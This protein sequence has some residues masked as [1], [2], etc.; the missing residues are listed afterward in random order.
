MEI[1]S[2]II[3]IT[4]ENVYYYHLDHLGT[5]VVMTDQ[6]QNIV[7]QASYD[8]FGQANI[9]VSTVTNNLRFPGMYADTETGLYYNMNRYYYP[10]IGRYIEPDPILQLVTTIPTPRRIT[11][12]VIQMASVKP[13]AGILTQ[14]DLNMF[15]NLLS[16]YSS[17]PEIFNPYVYVSNNPINVIDPL[18]EAGCLPNCPRVPLGFPQ[19]TTLQACHDV[20][21]KNF[22]KCVFCII[23]TGCETAWKTWQDNCAAAARD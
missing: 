5:P 22:P 13:I 12:W 21:T 8:P 11:N 15:G 10:A 23:P 18:G 7:W 16:M 1:K 19:P 9:S 14:N 6:N 2:I 17:H 20:Y 3:Q 4:G